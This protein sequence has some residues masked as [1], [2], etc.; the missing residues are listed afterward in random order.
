MTLRWLRIGFGSFFALTVALLANMTL[1]QP[2]PSAERA[3]PAMPPVAPLQPAP[4][5]IVTGATPPVSA[6]N[7]ATRSRP[8][9]VRGESSEIVKA[10]QR[11]LGSRGY[12]TGTPDG[13][14]GL[15][16]RASIMAYETDNNLPLTGRASEELLQAVLLGT[17]RRAAAPSTLPGPEAEQVIRTVQ[18]SLQRLGYASGPVDGRL[19]EVTVRTI[20][21]F[22]SDQGLPVTGRISGQ[23]VARL[24][25][26][27]GQ[28][29]ISDAR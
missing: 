6:L 3:R 26:L 9:A 28:G 2:L 19:G 23:L 1:L 29:R 7:P 16:T 13:M 11:E 10:I 25:R 12:E 4:A 5:E 8:A 20:R 17:E 27:A 22:E 24:A 18:Q 21:E 14:P 15:V